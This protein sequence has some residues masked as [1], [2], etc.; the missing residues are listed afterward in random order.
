[1][2][3]TV[4]SKQTKKVSQLSRRTQS[5]KKEFLHRAN[6]IRTIY[7]VCAGQHTRCCKYIFLFQTNNTFEAGSEEVQNIVLKLF[8]TQNIR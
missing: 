2:T 4:A 3:Y 5:K 1:M 7:Y 8:D 6:R